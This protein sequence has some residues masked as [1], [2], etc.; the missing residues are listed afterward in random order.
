[1]PRGEGRG[2]LAPRLGS[3]E[4]IARGARWAV[5]APE[6]K[7]PEWGVEFCSRRVS[8]GSAAAGPFFRGGAAFRHWAAPPAAALVIFGPLASIADRTV[9]LGDFC[10]GGPICSSGNSVLEFPRFRFGLARGQPR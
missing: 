3:G 8:L 4:K 9:V 6:E 10:R 1:M 2:G 5:A 7:P